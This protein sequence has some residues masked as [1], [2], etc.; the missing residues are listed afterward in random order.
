M[1]RACFVSDLHLFANRSRADRYLEAIERAADAADLCILGGDIFDFRWSTLPS[2][3]A[4]VESAVAWLRALCC[5]ASGT[6]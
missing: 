2:T 5:C 4:T 3:E 1:P 6:R